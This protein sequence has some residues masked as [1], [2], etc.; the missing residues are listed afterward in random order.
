MEKLLKAGNGFVS[1]TRLREKLEG[2]R[3]TVY[4]TIETY[5]IET[6][7]EIE[8]DSK[9]KGYRLVKEGGAIECGV[10][11]LSPN[12]I[13]VLLGV[14]R[15]L[16]QLSMTTL[17]GE[18]RPLR[19]R[20][21]KILR[22]EHIEASAILERLKVLSV[23]VRSI[24][25][26][27]FENCSRALAERRKLKISYLSRS[28]DE[29]TTRT[30]SPQHIVCYRDNWYL[31]AWCH[32][33]NGL[34]IFSLDRIRQSTV[35]KEKAKTISNKKLNQHYADAYGIFAGPA[36]AKAVLRFSP[37]VAKWVSSER[38]HP[39]Q[40]G[41]YLDD[42]TYELKFPYGHDRE[43]VMDILR[44]GPDVEVISPKKLRQ[45]VRKSLREALKKY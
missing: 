25:A 41:E 42:G 13:L 12:E 31:D 36:N 5:E 8:Y 15:Q 22:Q 6:G 23:E 44:Y 35:L 33:R 18:L 34:R 17:E 10:L 19:E 24:D 2:S 37:N 39:E 4:R 40:E 9:G 29:L 43:L 7:A 30:V 20:L 32:S 21:V 26:E 16:D 45:T 11:R 3:H 1:S 27:I 28:R 14:M 38:W